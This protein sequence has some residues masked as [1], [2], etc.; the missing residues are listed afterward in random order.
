LLCPGTTRGGGFLFG[1]NIK[2]NARARADMEKALRIDPD[3]PKVRDNLEVLGKRS[4]EGIT[5]EVPP[6]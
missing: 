5:S 6:H 1:G 3:L 2:N 4:I